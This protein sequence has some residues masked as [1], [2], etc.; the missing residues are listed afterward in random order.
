MLLHGEEQDSIRKVERVVQSI[1]EDCMYAVRGGKVIPNMH[2]LLP[3]N[4]KS[5]TRN[6][7]IIK[8]LNRLGHGISYSKLEE[9]DTALYLQKQNKEENRGIVLP[10][11][12]HPDILTT[13]A[14][15]NIDKLEETLS[16]RGTSHRLNGI[17]IQP[18]VHTVHPQ[19]TTTPFLNKKKCIVTVVPLDIQEYKA[20]NRAGPP[21]LKPQ[22]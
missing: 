9:I 6:V 19:K 2:I 18:Q 16:G 11:S 8:M 20:G 15:D 13:L 17:I 4:V 3:W 7:E 1:G 12:S 5:L 14:Y 22:E 10:S 21:V